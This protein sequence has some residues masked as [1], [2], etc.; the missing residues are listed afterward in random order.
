MAAPSSSLDHLDTV[1]F[2]LA[3]NDPMQDVN[4]AL[5]ACSNTLRHWHAGVAGPLPMSVCPFP[6]VYDSTAQRDQKWNLYLEKN[7][8]IA[9]QYSP[10]DWDDEKRAY[11]VMGNAISSANQRYCVLYMVSMQNPVFSH[12]WHMRHFNGLDTPASRAQFYTG[13]I[14][15]HEFALVL[16]QREV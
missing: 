7:P 4:A 10:A 11:G 8:E 13:D 14:E 3:H 9:A 12:S 2:N 1:N 6:V 5:M 15:W 16:N